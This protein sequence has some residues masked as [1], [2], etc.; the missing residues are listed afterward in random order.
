MRT[1]KW[2]EKVIQ[3]KKLSTVRWVKVG[4]IKVRR[5]CGGKAVCIRW[6]GMLLGCSLVLPVAVTRS[7]SAIGA[8]GGDGQGASAFIVALVAE[9]DLNG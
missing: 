4:K 9:V 1:S 2:M 5:Q 3:T 6:A 7:P 8:A